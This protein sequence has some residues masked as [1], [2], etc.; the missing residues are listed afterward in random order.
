MTQFSICLIR[1]PIL[2]MRGRSRGD[3]CGKT[4]AQTSHEFIAGSKLHIRP[5][6]INMKA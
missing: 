6:N 1:E 5:K 2:V 4:S 3:Q